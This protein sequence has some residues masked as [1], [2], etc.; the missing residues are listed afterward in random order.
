MCHWQLHF[1]VEA[2]DLLSGISADVDDYMNCST[3]IDAAV[4][5]VIEEVAKGFKF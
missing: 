3:A 4:D 2:V 1:K 5:K